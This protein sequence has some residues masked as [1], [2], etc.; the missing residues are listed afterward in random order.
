MSD[1]K[2]PDET[3][4]RERSAYT[5]IMNAMLTLEEP[6]RMK[7]LGAVAIMIKPALAPEPPSTPLRS[8]AQITGAE[9]PT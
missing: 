5:R 1:I 2:N 3:A 6:S 7:V 4:R 8:S 9:D